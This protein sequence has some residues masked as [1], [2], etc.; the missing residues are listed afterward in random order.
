MTQEESFERTVANAAASVEME[1]F[2][3]DAECRDWCRMLL[4]GEITLEQYLALVKKKAG[5][6]AS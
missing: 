1:G 6:T 3:V 4:A 5:V 2:H